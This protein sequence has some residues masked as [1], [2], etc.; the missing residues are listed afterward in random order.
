MDMAFP[1]NNYQMQPACH[2]Q[3]MQQQ[4]QRQREQMQEQ[5]QQM[6]EQMQRARQGQQEQMQEQRQQMQEQMQRQRDG[7]MQQQQQRQ[8]PS[9]IAELRLAPDGQYYAHPAFIEYYGFIEGQRKWDDAEQPFQVHADRHS[10]SV[11]MFRTANSGSVSTSIINNS[12]YVNGQHVANLDGHGQVQTINGQ[13]FVNGQVVWP[14]PGG[15]GVA[16]DVASLSGRHSQP[17]SPQQQQLYD[18]ALKFSAVSICEKD[19]CAEDC[20]ICLEP[21]MKGQWMTTLPCF[22]LFHRHCAEAHFDKQ[23]SSNA[24]AVEGINCP[25]CRYTIGPEVLEIDD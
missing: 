24:A 3:Q 12:V 6:Q 20:T 4:M 21:I 2:M 1:F 9:A 19:R 18:Q 22:H 8:T 5:M 11:S 10:G 14:R 25:V 7:Q 23:C 16:G 17:K 13:V 15:A